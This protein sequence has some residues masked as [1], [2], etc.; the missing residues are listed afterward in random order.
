M[1]GPGRDRPKFAKP[2]NSRAGI[3]TK[4]YRAPAITKH[5]GF[6]RIKKRLQVLS[7]RHEIGF[8]TRS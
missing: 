1:S 2:V 5:L 4:I 8:G 3:W 7:S 6:S